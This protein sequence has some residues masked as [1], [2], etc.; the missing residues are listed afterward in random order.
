[1]N[2]KTLSKREESIAKKQYVQHILFI[3]NGIKLNELYYNLSVVV[4]LWLNYYWNIY[5][6]YLHKITDLSSIGA[7]PT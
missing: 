4:S 1:M 7:M 6:A 3:K 5:P 2:N